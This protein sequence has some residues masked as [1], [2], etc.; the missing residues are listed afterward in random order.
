MTTLQLGSHHGDGGNA[1]PPPLAILLMLNYKNH[2]AYALFVSS[3]KSRHT[4]IKYDGC[5]Q[6]YFG[7]L[8][9]FNLCGTDLLL[10]GYQGYS[11]RDCAAPHWDKKFWNGVF[12]GTIYPASLYIFFNKRHLTKRKNPSRFV[13]GQENRCEYRSHIRMSISEICQGH[14]TGLD[15]AGYYK[16]STE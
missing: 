13:R 2:P 15:A 12:N 10:K 3:P 1:T 7:H 16:P 11:E 6:G 5:L 9:R 8:P 4:R 14:S